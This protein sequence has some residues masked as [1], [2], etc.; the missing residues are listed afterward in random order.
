MEIN[1]NKFSSAAALTA[2]IW[3][4]LCALIVAFLP[5]TAASLFSWMAHLVNV[6]EGIAFPEV[7]YGFIEILVL[8]YVTAYLFASLYNRFLRQ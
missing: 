5:S 1:K 8:A 7:I 4:I 3:Y 2:S 6:E